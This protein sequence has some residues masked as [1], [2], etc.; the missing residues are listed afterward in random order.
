MPKQILIEK[1]QHPTHIEKSFVCGIQQT[2]Y[3]WKNKQGKFLRKYNL[4]FLVVETKYYITYF[5][6]TD[7]EQKNLKTWNEKNKQKFTFED[8]CNLFNLD[9]Y[10]LKPAKKFV[11]KIINKILSFLKK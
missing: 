3:L 8:F 10:R 11:T 4:P 7:P 1:Y 9:Y 2:N 5:I 6:Y